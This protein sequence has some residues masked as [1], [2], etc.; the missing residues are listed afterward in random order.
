MANDIEARLEA[1]KREVEGLKGKAVTVTETI[2]NPAPLGLAGFGIT[3][4]L[5]NVVNAGIINKSDIG[6]VLPVGLFYGGL[7][8]LLAGM[9]EFKKNNTFG[10]TAFSSFGAFWLAFA[11][12][13]ILI[14]NGV[15]DPVSAEG[16]LTVFL[17]AWGIF[18]TYMFVGT[19]RISVALMVV[20]AALAILF[21]L[22]AWGEHNSDVHKI[23]GYEGLFT[24]GAALYASF[25]QVVNETWGKYVV[26]LGIIK[27]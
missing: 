3:T 23:A 5:L 21:Y 12:M 20:F 8:Q 9:W 6:M 22:L 14:M 2:A 25:A 4:L 10:A 27:K 7:A 11:V 15:M 1:L 17:V 13:E 26:P 18:T 19:L 16:G 24:A